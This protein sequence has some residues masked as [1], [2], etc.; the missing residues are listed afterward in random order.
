MV[1]R[2]KFAVVLAIFLLPL[3]YSHSAL[4]R[5]LSYQEAVWMCEQPNHAPSSSALRPAFTAG[6]FLSIAPIFLFFPLHGRTCRVLHFEP[7]RA[8]DHCDRPF[9]FD[10]MPSGNHPLGVREHGGAI[11]LDMLVERQPEPRRAWPCE[12]RN[13]LES[14]RR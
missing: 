11:G 6:F 5:S 9:R 8:N 14:W 12:P 13:T 1:K 10:T 2:L 4:S 3:A 7:V